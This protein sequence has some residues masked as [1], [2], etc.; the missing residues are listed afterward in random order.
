M[1]QLA[2]KSTGTLLT[3]TAQVANEER[4]YCDPISMYVLYKDTSAHSRQ[5]QEKKKQ[6]K[7]DRYERTKAE[8]E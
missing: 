7:G 5:T 3:L 6:R 4:S 8:S 2:N 1:R